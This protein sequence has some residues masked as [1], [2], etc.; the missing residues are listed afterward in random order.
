MK[1]IITQLGADAP[2]ITITFI[3]TIALCSSYSYL[4]ERSERK[5]MLS[6]LIKN[7]KDSNEP[8]SQA[9]ANTQHN[10]KIK[11]L[12]KVHAITKDKAEALQ[13]GLNKQIIEIQEEAHQ[14]AN[15]LKV[16]SDI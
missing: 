15:H 9:F 5:R 14:L 4:K 7:P 10:L 16:S 3:V 6:E 12:M 2:V 11:R 13:E 1:G 8:T